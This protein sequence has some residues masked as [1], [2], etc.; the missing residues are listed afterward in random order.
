[1]GWLLLNLWSITATKDAKAGAKKEEIKAIIYNMY[2]N[3]HL[4]I[5]SVY[6]EFS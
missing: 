5:N 6:M 1:M 2:A 4:H 3:T